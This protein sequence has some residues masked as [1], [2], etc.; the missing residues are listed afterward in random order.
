MNRCRKVHLSDMITRFWGCMI[1]V[2]SYKKANIGL[3]VV[4]FR[5]YAAIG[6]R[7]LC[8]LLKVIAV[9]GI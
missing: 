4:V 6:G 3:H 1:S 9:G 7:Q 8:V 5:S 2:V